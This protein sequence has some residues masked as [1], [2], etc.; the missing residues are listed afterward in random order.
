MSQF[1]CHFGACAPII[2]Q[3]VLNKS[4]QPH[5]QL[6]KKNQNQQSKDKKLQS[7]RLTDWQTDWLASLVTPKKQN[8]KKDTETLKPR[9]TVMDNS[10]DLHV[11]QL[12]PVQQQQ[13]STTRHIELS[14]TRGRIEENAK[15]RVPN[16]RPEIGDRRPKTGTGDTCSN[17][18]QKL[19]GKRR[20]PWHSGLESSLSEQLY[21]NWYGF[22]GEVI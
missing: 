3:N 18:P 10:H 11:R 17:S 20:T 22:V 7:R 4:L 8:W 21:S 16:R 14:L 15:A 12:L 9:R 1:C 6:P 5:V 2:N 19:K 13:S